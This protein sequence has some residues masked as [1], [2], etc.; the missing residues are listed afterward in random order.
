MS[1]IIPFSYRLPKEYQY[2][3][4]GGG[5]IVIEKH[6]GHDSILFFTYR[7]I[8]YSSSGFVYSPKDQ[9]PLHSDY[10]GDF[11]EIIKLDSKWYFVSSN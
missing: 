3:S 5:E 1:L 8:L 7:G 6:R 10:V 4:K 11:I 9:K 2:L